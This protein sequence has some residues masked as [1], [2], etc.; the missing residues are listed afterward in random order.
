MWRCGLLAI[1]IVWAISVRIYTD[2][3]EALINKWSW[4]D[5]F[6]A[7]T[8]FGYVFLTTSYRSW[9]NQLF[10]RYSVVRKLKIVR[11]VTIYSDKLSSS[12]YTTDT[13]I[14]GDSSR[15]RHFCWQWRSPNGHRQLWRPFWIS[16]SPKDGF[17]RD[18]QTW[19]LSLSILLSFAPSLFL[20]ELS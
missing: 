20:W 9:T 17:L 10:F 1:K 16:Y 6:N 15:G 2:F 13:M 8:D 14:Q 7:E 5:W 4:A 11:K 19:W 18:S 12:C 3:C